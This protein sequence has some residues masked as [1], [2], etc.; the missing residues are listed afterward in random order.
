[1]HSSDN[2]EFAAFMLFVVIYGGRIGM[3]EGLGAIE[4]W[5]PKIRRILGLAEQ[6]AG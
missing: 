3:V 2:P 4:E 6:T 1:M 5:M